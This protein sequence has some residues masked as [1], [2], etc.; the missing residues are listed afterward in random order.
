[1]KKTI[2]LL[3]FILLL[4]PIVIYGWFVMTTGEHHYQR[5]DIISY[6]LYTPDRVKNTPEISSH[7]QFS[8]YSDPDDHHTTVTIHWS[9]I[10]DSATKKKQL[11]YYLEQSRGFKKYDCVWIYQD[12]KD[13]SNNYQRYC[14]YQKGKAL[15]LIVFQ[16]E[17]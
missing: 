2:W 8:Y 17:N 4:P 1:M 14:V 10:Q 9:D 12:E 16:T 7:V 13:Y 3:V 6:W 11:L 5:S 15:A